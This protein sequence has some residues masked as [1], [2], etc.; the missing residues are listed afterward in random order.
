M[1]TLGYGVQGAFAMV[2]DDLIEGGFIPVILQNHI[3]ME[4]EDTAKILTVIKTLVN[5]VP[6]IT[7]GNMLT[8][9]PTREQS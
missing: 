1:N 5:T 4:E 6:K 9:N 2:V 8:T 3:M 7:N